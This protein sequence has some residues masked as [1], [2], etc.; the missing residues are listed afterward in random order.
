MQRANRLADASS[1]AKRADAAPRQ[2]KSKANAHLQPDAL[3]QPIDRRAVVAEYETSTSKFP[4]SHTETDKNGPLL[5]SM[6]VVVHAVQHL[7]S[8]RSIAVLEVDRDPRYQLRNSQVCAIAAIRC[9]SVRLAA[10]GTN[11]TTDHLRCNAAIGKGEGAAGAL[12]ASDAHFLHWIAVAQEFC[13]GQ[14]SHIN[15]MAEIRTLASAGA[16]PRRTASNA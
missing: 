10:R 12:S 5:P 2:A 9:S 13:S 1:A 16:F 6:G 7:R 14:Q 4:I 15:Q 3:H 8:G 11:L